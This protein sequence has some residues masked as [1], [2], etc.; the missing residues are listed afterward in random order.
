VDHYNNIPNNNKKKKNEVKRPQHITTITSSSVPAVPNL[1]NLE[2]ITTAAEDHGDTSPKVLVRPRT[3]LRLE[4]EKAAETTSSDPDHLLLQTSSA[5]TNRKRSQQ[6]VAS[7]KAPQRILQQQQQQ[8]Q[9]VHK[10]FLD[11]CRNVLGIQT[12][13]EIRYFE[14]P[15]TLPQRP[16]YEDD[17]RTEHD[18]VDAQQTYSNVQTETA[19]VTTKKS[20]VRGLAAPRDIAAGEILIRIPVQALVSVATTI[21][22]D[23]I[24][25]HVLGKQARNK[26]RWYDEDDYNDTEEYPHVD[27]QQQ[28]GEASHVEESIMVP[29]VSYELGILAVGL[30]HH[31]RLGLASP[32]APYVRDI[33]LSNNDVRNELP[34]LWDNVH[35]LQTTVS[36]GVRII[37]REMRQETRILYERIVNVLIREYPEIFGYTAVDEQG[38]W[39]YSYENFQWAVGI[40]HS[41]HWQLPIPDLIDHQEDGGA[42]SNDAPTTT[43]RNAPPASLGE[44]VPPASVPTDAWIQQSMGD[45]DTADEKNHTNHPPQPSR[46]W[47]RQY[48]FLAPVADLLNFGPPCTRT[49]YDSESK[50]FQVIATCDLQQGQEVTFW[51]GNECDDVMMAVYGISHPLI[52]ACKTS[53]EWRIRVETLEAILDATRSDL[54]MLESELE[55]VETVLK[56]CDCCF[57]SSDED[58]DEE[59]LDEEEANMRRRGDANTMQAHHGGNS[60]SSSRKSTRGQMQAPPKS[61]F[62]RTTWSRK[63][64]F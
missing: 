8:Q 23:P 15:L 20:V 7:L 27:S 22:Q 48:S 33:L 11:W 28:T 44:Q 10:H 12:L 51:Y 54:E 47:P 13:L 24:L 18:D 17:L 64:E 40:V 55:Y 45:T 34:F 57:L 46:E 35:R 31:R 59:F 50:T 61:R 21:D 41:R 6:H 2:T 19:S 49:R 1:H 4:E 56:D 42:T 14:Y 37:A 39:I 62:R 52:P 36:E 53:E 16:D 9:I 32:L 5:A 60:K 29:V 63:T 3:R 26:H 58:E 38:D 30:L 43:N 25:G